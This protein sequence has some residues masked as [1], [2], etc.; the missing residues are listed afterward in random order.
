MKLRNFFYS[1]FI[2]ISYPVQSADKCFDLFEGSLRGFQNEVKYYSYLPEFKSIKAEIELAKHWRR[3][4]PKYEFFKQLLPKDVGFIDHA[5]RESP[6][7]SLVKFNEKGSVVIVRAAYSPQGKKLETNVSVSDFGLTDNLESQ[8]K[9]LIG[10]SIPAGVLFLHG[11]GTK[12]TGGHVAHT[13]INHFKKYGV[14]FISP[15]LSW[16]AEGPRTVMESLDQEI[17]ALSNFVKKYVHPKVPLFVWGH[18]WGGSLAHRLMQMSGENK[19][20][21]FHNNLKG[22]IITSPA[23]DPAPGQSIRE[24]MKRYV[25]RRSSIFSEHKDNISPL[26]RDI[27]QNMVLNGKTSPVGAFFT[28]LTIS[29]LD[30][31]IPDHKGSAYPPSI[32][33][34]GK[35]DPLVYVGLKKLFEDYYGQLT[36]VSSHYLEKLPLFVDPNHEHIV[37]HLLSDYVSKKGD[38]APVN[39]K[40]ATNFIM[41]LVPEVRR[42]EYDSSMSSVY[43]ILK[44]YSNDLAFRKWVES[45]D[46]IEITRKSGVFQDLN[47]EYQKKKQQLDDLIAS[48]HPKVWLYHEL[49]KLKYQN[50]AI[51]ETQIKFLS[52]FKEFILHKSFSTFLENIKNGDDYLND[53][54]DK[55]EHQQ[56]LSS[57]SGAKMLRNF[58]K[59]LKVF[60]EQNKLPAFF[61]K[62]FYISKLQQD[63]I[64]TFLKQI[65]D[66]E[67]QQKEMY[68]PSHED[69][70]ELN[71]EKVQKRIDSIK[72]NVETR[73][74]LEKKITALKKEIEKLK[75]Q[76]NKS[77]KQLVQYIKKVK[78]TFEAIE[79]APS[80]SM[81]NLYRES[82]KDFSQLYDFSEKLH[83]NMEEEIVKIIE[84]GQ[85]TID[86]LNDVTEKYK[87]DVNKFEDMY[88][89]FI[90]NRK[91]IRKILIN[92]VRDGDFTEEQAKIFNSLYGDIGIYK[93]MDRM[94]LELAEKE[95]QY[96][97]LRK[98]FAQNLQ[99]YHGLLPGQ[100]ISEVAI[101]PIRDIFN[102]KPSKDTLQKVLEAWNFLGSQ[103]LPPLPE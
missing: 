17:M 93:N 29:Q 70:L 99:K 50:K 77:E 102:N 42:I 49:Q 41:R 95:A 100:T 58:H 87:E 27:F 45:A 62:Y 64:I 97:K 18:S 76:L 33:I 65:K 38:S 60:I 26:E 63:E 6:S 84:S 79:Q 25:E 89:K 35:G 22:L 28:S 98:S 24:K 83:D 34:V 13:M 56:V 8:Q 55:L 66:I 51:D 94:S 86:V 74:Q 54:V 72:E 59:E 85:I 43:T 32:M 30:D 40:L 75:L 19:K 101:F 7:P 31:R 53:E 20:G 78:D 48:V 23:I 57:S 39:F 9:W 4:D 10:P 73:Q 46:L 16:H 15:D 71:G 36:N 92:R 12:S 44:L 103:S 52:K 1:A 47:T 68:I 11:G 81:I 14:A 21:F 69:F 90:A 5:L 91:K 96:L 61:E 37:G 82:E 2:I 88:N 3:D 67:I 80:A